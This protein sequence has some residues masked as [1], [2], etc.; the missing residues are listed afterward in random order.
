MTNPSFCQD[1]KAIGL[2][3]PDTLDSSAKQFLDHLGLPTVHPLCSD[4]TTQA[5]IDTTINEK[6]NNIDNLTIIG[7]GVFELPS[8]NLNTQSAIQIANNLPQ[9]PI[10]DS[11]S[12]LELHDNSYYQLLLT[13]TT[14]SAPTIAMME[15][16][17]RFFAVF[18][19]P[20]CIC[21]LL[22]REITKTTTIRDAKDT[23]NQQ[24][25]KKI[26]IRF[27]FS[28]KNLKFLLIKIKSNGNIKTSINVDLF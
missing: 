22:H 3:Q 19:C 11:I 16:W 10:I 24:D 18:I 17:L 4:D 9:P 26:K 1:V 12:L 21:W 13:A 15:L 25:K 6:L 7:H 27:F 14:M 23:A 5:T 28:N 8:I 2:E 20:V